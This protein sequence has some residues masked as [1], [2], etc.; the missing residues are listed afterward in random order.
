MATHRQQ[1]YATKG[2]LEAIL[3]FVEMKSRPLKFVPT[4]VFSNAQVN[5]LDTLIGHFELGIATSPESIGNRG[6][7]VLERE[8]PVS[9]AKIQ[10]NA[11]DWYYKFEIGDHNTVIFRPAGILEHGTLILS[12]VNVVSTDSAT[13]ALFELF[14]RE[15]KK[16]S[17]MVQSTSVC[18]EA[19]QLLDDG[20]V[21]TDAA[22]TVIKRQLKRTKDKKEFAEGALDWIDNIKQPD[23]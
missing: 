22:N 17:S 15:I 19:E 18:K 4:G 9:M 3:S 2:D 6:Y 23:K 13:L 12:E 7:Y 20:W 21:L 16:Q 1:F 10:N 8:H 5:T 14:R 11:K